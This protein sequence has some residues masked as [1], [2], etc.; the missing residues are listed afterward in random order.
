MMM[1]SAAVVPQTVPTRSVRGVA[2]ERYVWRSWA[3]KSPAMNGTSSS[4]I[5]VSAAMTTAL[6][7]LPAAPRVSSEKLIAL[8]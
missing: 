2:L 4:T 7:M 5:P 6:P 8:S 1:M 3:P